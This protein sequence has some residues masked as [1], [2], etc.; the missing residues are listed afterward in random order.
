MYPYTPTSEKVSHT[1]TLFGYQPTNQSI[2]KFF[3]PSIFL[4]I[5]LSSC[6]SIYLSIYLSILGDCHCTPLPLPLPSIHSSPR[7]RVRLTG[8]DQSVSVA[9]HGN[10]CAHA[11]LRDCL[12][13]RSYSRSPSPP[14]LFIA[15]VHP[16]AAGNLIIILLNLKLNLFYGR[17]TLNL[18]T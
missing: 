13:L 14:P 8:V 16:Q 1:H 2:Y 15:R 17:V 5:F 6:V 9:T 12:L 4:F 7:R 3:N 10:R 11:H 18:I